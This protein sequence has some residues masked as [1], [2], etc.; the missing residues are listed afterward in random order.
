MPDMLVKLY[1]LPPLA[2]VIEAQRQAGIDIR[3]ALAPEKHVVIDWVR[4][5]FQELWASETDVSFSNHPVSCFIA[6]END[7]MIGFACYDS[8]CKNFFGP[9]GVDETL[10]GRGTGKALLLACLHAIREQGFGYAIIGAAGPTDFYA[11]A[12]GAIIIENSW[13][14]IYRGLLRKEEL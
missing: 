6:V 14:G 4:K 7:N 1:E 2:P 11:K 5:N 12:V 3:R 9:T 10:R 13:P 8:T